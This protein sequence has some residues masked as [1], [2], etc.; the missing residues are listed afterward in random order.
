MRAPHLTNANDMRKMLFSML[1][2]Y[3]TSRSSVHV[4]PSMGSRAQQVCGGHDAVR[5]GDGKSRLVKLPPRCAGPLSSS[6][7]RSLQRLR[8]SPERCARPTFACVDPPRWAQ[9]RSYTMAPIRWATT[10]CWSRASTTGP[11]PRLLWRQCSAP[12][13]AWKRLNRALS[14]V[15]PRPRQLQ[16]LGSAQ[17]IRPY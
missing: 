5:L 8:G 6:R 10:M 14:S 15:M 9:C 13:L 17:P 1:P 12:D 16:R 3:L 7:R 4:L 2:L 11:S